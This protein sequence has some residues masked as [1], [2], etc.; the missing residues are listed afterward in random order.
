[1]RE[2]A[3]VKR[4]C[5]E[6]GYAFSQGSLHTT[7]TITSH[8]GLCRWWESQREI[9]VGLQFSLKLRYMQLPQEAKKG[10]PVAALATLTSSPK[11]T[12]CTYLNK[13]NRVT[14]A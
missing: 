13:V 12:N 2:I 3:C 5:I 4:G 11:T 7:S 8:E 10:S 9:P 6:T 1:M 14:V